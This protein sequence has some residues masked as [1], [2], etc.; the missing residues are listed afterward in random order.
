MITKQN[1]IDFILKHQPELK[2]KK[3]EDLSIEELVILKVQIE[4]TLNDKSA[5][6][7]KNEN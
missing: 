6:K 5:N 2:N 1:I 4:I 3:L 7:Q